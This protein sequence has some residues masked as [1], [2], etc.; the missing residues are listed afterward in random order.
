MVEAHRNHTH[1]A[2]VYLFA[3]SPRVRES[4]QRRA[5][6]RRSDSAP[7]PITSSH[8]GWVRIALWCSMAFSFFALVVC[9]YIMYAKCQAGWPL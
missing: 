8:V 2:T 9:I 1:E 7:R 3:K 4:C 5:I 6:H